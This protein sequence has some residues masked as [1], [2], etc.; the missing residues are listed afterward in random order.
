MI[1][2]KVVDG[3]EDL[4]VDYDDKLK[5]A[6]QTKLHFYIAAEI[7]NMPLNEAPWKF[8][9]GDSRDSVAYS[10]RELERGHEYIVY[11]RAITRKS[12]VSKL[13]SAQ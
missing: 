8:T 3:V 1:V 6:S 4:P 9:V 7:N 5:D 2:L 12:S 13:E 11:Q 10:N